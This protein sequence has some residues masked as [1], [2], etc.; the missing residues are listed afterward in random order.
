[1]CAV[2][3]A[4]LATAVSQ[5]TPDCSDFK[6]WQ[7]LIFPW[8]C[9]LGGACSRP[10]RWG[11]WK[12]RGC[13]PRKPPPRHPLTQSPVLRLLLAVSGNTPSGPPHGA[14]ASSCHG[15][16]VP[17]VSSFLE[18][19]LCRRCVTFLDQASEVMRPHFCC[20]P[21]AGAPQGPS[22]VQGEATHSPPPDQASRG[23]AQPAGPSWGSSLPW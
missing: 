15:G 9:N 11:F 20:S 19:E 8:I 2:S 23:P 13:S 21:L 1:M 12:T 5:M 18:R 22:H 16:C 17:R 10:I 6:Q 7:R 3:P 4:P 14:W